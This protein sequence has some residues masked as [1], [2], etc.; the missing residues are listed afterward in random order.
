[1]EKAKIVRICTADIKRCQ[2]YEK[3]LCKNKKK[4]CLRGIRLELKRL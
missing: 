1:M 4:C 3:G 2:S